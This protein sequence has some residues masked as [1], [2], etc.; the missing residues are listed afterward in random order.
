MAVNRGGYLLERDRNSFDFVRFAAALTIIFGHSFPQDPLVTLSNGQ[1]NLG[2]CAVAIFFMTSGFLITMSIER[3]QNWVVYVK[4]RFLRIYP[5]LIVVVLL[6]IFVLG[7]LM[8]TLTL[9]AYFSSPTTYGY[10][11][12]LLLYKTEYPLPGVFGSNARFPRLINGSLWTL[13]YEAVLYAFVLGLWA[14]RLLRKRLVLVGFIIL[15]FFRLIMIDMY[16]YFVIRSRLFHSLYVIS[17]SV[18]ISTGTELLLYFMAGML[19]YLYRDKISLRRRYFLLSI[20]FLLI[21]LVLQ[22]GLFKPWCAVWGAYDLF[23]L[24][25]SQRSPF[26][27]FGKH[28]DFSYGIYI[29]AFPIQQS[30]VHLFGDTLPQMVN[31]A[32]TTVITLP[33]A[34]LSWHFVEKPALKLKNMTLSFFD[35]PAVRET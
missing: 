8:T 33:F 9:G 13:F 30:L 10:A 11:R 23:Y 4:A 29:Y 26:K 14:V 31:F 28:G 5:A 21:V 7:P 32:L 3:S 12:V 34:I 17:N 27:R 18:N 19:F 1:Y 24:V 2:R 25:S 15:L 35:K 16:P 20:P 22:V 6:S